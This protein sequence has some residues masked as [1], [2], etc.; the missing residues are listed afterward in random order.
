MGPRVA[1]PND[2]FLL[3]G[4]NCKEDHEVVK[5]FTD[6]LAADMEVIEKKTYIVM[7]KEVSFSFDL[8][9]GGHEIPG[10]YQC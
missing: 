4:A 7:G 2:N 5:R 6:K 1:S 3:F 8:L 10:F 9:P